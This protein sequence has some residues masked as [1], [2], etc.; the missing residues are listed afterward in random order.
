[1]VK[2]KV[3]LEKLASLMVEGFESV[4][5]DVATLQTDMTEAKRDITEIKES[6]QAQGKAVD[7]DAKTLINHEARIKKLEHAR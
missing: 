5:G 4:R 7:L 6:L 2:A 1:M 3:T